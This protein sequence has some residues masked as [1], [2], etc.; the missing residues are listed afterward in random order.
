MASNVAS[1][2]PPMKPNNPIHV[3]GRRCG[4]Y[5][6]MVE[7]NDE[8]KHCW[9]CGSQYVFAPDSAPEG[10]GASIRVKTKLLKRLLEH[11]AAD[12][13]NEVGILCRNEQCLTRVKRG[14]DLYCRQCRV[15]IIER[16]M[17]DARLSLAPS[18]NAD[19]TPTSW[20]VALEEVPVV[21]GKT[22]TFGHG[23]A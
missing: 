5:D 3:R 4:R 13:S 2:G 6:C 21:E 22:T 11:E 14:V 20:K 8:D 15:E 12:K 17:V 1:N 7:F 9:R 19:A 18:E 23:D 10:F 16:G